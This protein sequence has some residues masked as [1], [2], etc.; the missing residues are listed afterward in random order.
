VLLSGTILGMKRR[1]ILRRFDEIVAF[2]ELEQFIDTPVKRY[3]SGMYLRLAFA[4]AAHLEPEILV[5][6]EVLAVGDAAFQKACLGRLG[7]VARQGRTVLFVSHHMP[8]VKALCTRVLH[9][10]RGTIVDDGLPQTVVAAYLASATGGLSAERTWEPAERPGNSEFRLAALRVTNPL[11]E[12]TGVYSS[13]EAMFVEMEFELR[14][15]HPALVVG[16]DLINRDGVVLFKSMHN[17]RH[18]REWPPVSEGYNRI[19]CEIPAGWLNGGTYFVAPKVGLH[20]ICYYLNGEAEVGFDVL[21]D[22][23]ESPFWNTDSPHKF[24]GV[25]APCLPWRT[26]NGEARAHA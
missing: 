13:S 8:A 3:S 4:V 26:C 19:R 1:E 18:P 17:D 7:E 2:A 5:V 20:S 10:C 24:N 11:G 6:D 22:H 23:S 9:L 25:I 16:F 21:L 14:S 15:A 12:V